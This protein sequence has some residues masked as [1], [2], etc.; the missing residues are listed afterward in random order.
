[1]SSKRD[2]AWQRDNVDW[3]RGS[4]RE[5]KEVV[6]VSWADVNLTGSRNEENQRDRFNWYKWTMKI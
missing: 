1:M 3:R 4:I 6:N 2:T 5:G